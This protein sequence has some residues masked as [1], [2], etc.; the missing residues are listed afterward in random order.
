MFFF[1]EYKFAICLANLTVDLY[2]DDLRYVMYYLVRLVS[3]NVPEKYFP[4]QIYIYSKLE[5]NQY[6]T[7]LFLRLKDIFVEAKYAGKNK[8]QRRAELF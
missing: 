6:K 5:R 3:L 2:V 7:I 4:D 1:F 8:R